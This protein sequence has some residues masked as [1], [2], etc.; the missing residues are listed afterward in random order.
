MW[1]SWEGGSRGRGHMYTYGWFILMYG[2]NQHN[3][4]IILQLKINEFLK[5][6]YFENNFLNPNEIC[7]YPTECLLCSV[8]KH[9]YYSQGSASTGLL[10]PAR[11]CTV[12]S[13]LIV[14]GYLDVNIPFT[15]LEV[16]PWLGSILTKDLSYN[17][18]YWEWGGGENGGKQNLRHTAVV[19]KL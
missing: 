10:H 2:R 16:L 9:W 17:V 15:V 7:H 19:L 12:S 11:F 1:W 6:I 3:S 14:K 5:K 13:N 4:V 8:M 18:L